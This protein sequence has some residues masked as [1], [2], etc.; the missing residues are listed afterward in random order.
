MS[1][2]LT[3]LEI[4]IPIGLVIVILITILWVLYYQNREV[5][6]KLAQEKNKMN[7]YKKGVKDVEDNPS[8]NPKDD[9][10]K[11][12]KIARAFFKEFYNLDSNL[13]YLELADRF[14]K[15]KR[16]NYIIF[17]KTM[18]EWSYS[19]KAITSLELRQLADLLYKM[20]EEY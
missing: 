10:K 2:V 20:V 15:L 11:L 14:K 3:S 9:F 17:C 18:S 7:S 8:E 12:N 1:L 13:T 4:I 16:E 19:G 6:K 5:Y